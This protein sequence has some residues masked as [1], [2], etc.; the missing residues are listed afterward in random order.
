MT[1]CTPRKALQCCREQGHD[2]CRVSADGEAD[3][4]ALAA[5]AWCQAASPGSSPAL[6]GEGISKELKPFDRG[7][8]KQI[9]GN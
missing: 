6:G 9:A 4:A 2:A 1:L 7:T 8:N 3:V 5:R